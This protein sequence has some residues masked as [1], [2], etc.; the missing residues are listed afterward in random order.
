[1][2]RA[3]LPRPRV[4][5]LLAALAL[6][7]VLAGASDFVLRGRVYAQQTRVHDLYIGVNDNY[8]TVTGDGST[9]LDCWI[10]D[11]DGNLVDSDTD[12]T[13]DCVLS[14]PGIGQHRL[15]IKNFGSVY[16][17]YVVARRR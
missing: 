4:A 7:P 6:A 10:F 13:D 16:N 17:D 3:R 2:L 1:M 14:T 5:L 11:G 15:V 12:N 9:D 8:V